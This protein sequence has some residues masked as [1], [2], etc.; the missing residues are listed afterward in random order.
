MRN[1]YKVLLTR[2]MVGSVVYS[3]DPETQELLAGLVG[4]RMGAERMGD[5]QK[6][7]EFGRPAELNRGA[8]WQP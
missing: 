6:A 2:G 8:T 1:T 7:A 3:T 4:W 5:L